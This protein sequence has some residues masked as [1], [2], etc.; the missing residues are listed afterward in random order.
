MEKNNFKIKQIAVF[1]LAAVI[2]LTVC[3]CGEEPFSPSVV[4]TDSLT[5][6]GDVIY[7]KFVNRYFFE[8]YSDISTADGDC[9]VTLYKDSDFSVHFEGDLLEL[10]DGTNTFYLLIGNDRDTKAFTVIIDCIMIMDF[11]IRILEEKQYKTGDAFD[12]NSIEVT[13]EKEDGTSIIVTD[14]DVEYDFSEKGVSRVRISY[15]GIVHFIETDV[16]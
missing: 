5:I 16:I 2:I 9:Y 12:R 10:E 15:G 1:V 13:A 3:S 6:N 8:P 14:Y 11:D 7:G 4:V